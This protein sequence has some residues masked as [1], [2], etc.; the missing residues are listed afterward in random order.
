MKDNN[1]LIRK[2]LINFFKQYSKDIKELLIQ[3]AEDKKT[4]TFNRDI[5][6]S[7][8]SNENFQYYE[9]YLEPNKIYDEFFQYCLKFS[10]TH[11]PKVFPQKKLSKKEINTTF[12]NLYTEFND[13][14]DLLNDKLF[15]DLEPNHK[16]DK[17]IEYP[18][19]AIICRFFDSLSVIDN[20][21]SITILLQEA[22]E[23]D[24]YENIAKAV[25]IDPN[26]LKVSKIDEY[27]NK[28]DL[29][30]KTEVFQKCLIERNKPFLSNNKNQICELPYFYV[31]FVYSV[32][33]IDGAI[34]L[35]YKIHKSFA[36]KI[37]ALDDLEDIEYFREIF[38][39]FCKSQGIK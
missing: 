5:I 28:L 36:D 17:E 20:K 12:S 31:S 22:L 24:K 19:S 30:I 15:S 21:K 38:D 11:F 32:G 35:P 7:F 23:D 8:L 39:K 13:D 37:G 4:E 34:P 27:I 3:L 25:S 10:T 18:L 16:F 26:I 9:L 29:E 6:S 33:L 14:I 2:H 1:W